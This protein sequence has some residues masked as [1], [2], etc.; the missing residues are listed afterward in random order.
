MGSWGWFGL[1][2]GGLLDD[3]AGRFDASAAD[4]P[5]SQGNPPRVATDF[6]KLVAVRLRFVFLENDIKLHSKRNLVQFEVDIPPAVAIPVRIVQ[7]LVPPCGCRSRC[8]KGTL[9]C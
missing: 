2:V 5:V 4:L 9:A 6:R 3:V 1:R 7:D 8:S